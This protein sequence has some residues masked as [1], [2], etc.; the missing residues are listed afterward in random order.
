SSQD[1]TVPGFGFTYYDISGT[2]IDGTDQNMIEKNAVKRVDERE[3]KTEYRLEMDHDPS[4]PPSS[5]G[6]ME[7]FGNPSPKTGKY[8]YTAEKSVSIRIDGIVYES[9]RD[10]RHV[11]TGYTLS[12]ESGGN[13][14]D[15]F[16][17]KSPQ[18]EHSFNL[19]MDGPKKIFFR[20]KNEY[21]FQV[22]SMPAAMGD[23]L[24]PKAGTYWYDADTTVTSSASNG[25]LQVTGYRDNI[26]ALTQTMPGKTKTYTMDMPVQ[27][28]WQYEAHNYEETV[29][30]GDS[31]TFKGIPSAVLGRTDT[32]SEPVRPTSAD[33]SQVD[34]GAEELYHWSISDRKLFPLIGGQTFQVEW[35]SRSGSQCEQKLISTIHTQWPET[36]H[37]VHVADTPPV[38]L[39]PQEDDRFAFKSLK[40]TSNEAEVSQALE[41]TASK[42]G[43]ST[44]L[45]TTVPSGAATGDEN[46]ENAYVRVVETRLWT[47]DKEEGTA[48]IGLELT[49]EHHSPDTPHNGY[50]FWDRARY[51]VNI[52]D[53]ETMQGQI[54]PVNRQFTSA[55]EDNLV[56]VWYQIIDNISWP[57]QPVQYISQWPTN[58]K[59]EAAG[60]ERITSRIVIASR[61]GSECAIECDCGEGGSEC[62]D[63][64]KTYPTWPDRNGTEQE[65]LDP[66]RYKDVMIYQQPDPD[67]P[68]YNPNE[69]HAVTAPSFRHGKMASPPVAAFALR[70]DLNITAKDKTHTSENY[71]LLQY[72]DT[73]ESKYAMEVFDI[74]KEDDNCGY[75][76][77]YPMRAGDPVVAPYP[78]NLVIG[79][80]P[81]SEICGRN[82][83]P[84]RNCYWEDHKGQSW[85]VSGDA[86]LFAY[87]WYPLAPEFWYEKNHNGENASEGP[88]DPIPWLPDGIVNSES[89]FPQDMIGKPKAVRVRYNTEWPDEVP[90]L[91]AGETVTYAGGEYRADHPQT[92]EGLPMVLGWAAGQVI[93]DDL[94]PAMDD[95]KM[96]HSYLVRLV[97]ALE[98]RAADLPVEDMPEEL[99]PAAG[100]VKA[101]GGRW[102]F[103]ELHAGLKT[104]IFYDPMTEKLGIRGFVNGKT[105]GDADLTASPPSVYV[106]QPNILTQEEWGTLRGM[107]GA[108]PAFKAAVDALYNLT[109]DP[110]NLMYGAYTVGLSDARK[111]LQTYHET[112]FEKQFD[113]MCGSL[114]SLCPPCGFDTMC[115]KII[116]GDTSGAARPFPEMA[117]GPGLALVPSAKLLDPA[118]DIQD[119]YVTVAE[120]NHPS[121]GSLP[122]ALHIVKVVNDKYRG[123]IKTIESDNVFDEKIT[124]RHT[125]DFGANP[126]DAEFEWRYREEDGTEQPPPDTAPEGTWS[127]FPGKE[128]EIA[129]EG[130]GAALLT[131]NLF[132]CRYRHKDSDGDEP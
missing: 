93:F 91:K 104:R 25:C 99:T 15:D 115:A 126:G 11:C 7:N 77:E 30:I 61:E 101:V 52:Y 128:P 31:V 49:S 116:S 28:T 100:K 109:R 44:L 75:K 27:I 59:E 87:F 35:Q 108:N 38:P 88:G 85:A 16:V 83:N 19:R 125:A 42:E 60:E 18:D 46:V 73:I 95:K 51:N 65:Y 113:D 90:I 45:L 68:G 56:V 76:F 20:W 36:P 9:A 14:V 98:E 70:D 112:L 67:L 21:S 6:Y 53:R 48:E 69:E 23:N 81:P 110:A 114:H 89:L 63:E 124:L 29:I 118:S 127:A 105:L 54:F 12:R 47:K 117:L 79:A 62:E 111:E 66:A 43:K 129:M 132:F 40:Y 34:Q 5:S 96:F 78:L 72:Y 94:N 39:D 86:H 119:G 122:V 41:F 71:V 82:G 3:G 80:A 74:E 84:D 17:R 32:E 22:M 2:K 102:Y 131:D 33:P 57:Y 106:L 130:A 1:V 58:E 121:L 123:A 103:K 13:F 55:L 37:Y 26:N 107:E 64:Q 97:Q 4:A 120:N 92:R 50:V 8:W 10:T 24:T